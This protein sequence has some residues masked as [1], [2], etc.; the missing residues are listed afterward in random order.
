MAVKDARFPQNAPG[1][2]YVDSQ[3]IACRLCATEAPENFKM[4]DDDSHAFV[5]KQPV[6][7]AEQEACESVRKA[8][9]VEAIGNDG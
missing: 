9:P 4:A 5:S 1:R 6:G 7:N 8:C 2:Y 3:C